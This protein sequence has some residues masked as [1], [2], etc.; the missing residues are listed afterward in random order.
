[1]EFHPSRLP[2]EKI[3]DLRDEKDAS[4]AAEEIVRLGFEN[5]KNG[6]RMLMPKDSTVAKRIGHIVTTGV[7]YGLRQKNKE[8]DIMYW[9]YHHDK[10]HY[11]IVFISA[12]VF[13]EL[14]F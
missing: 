2:I 9:T 12:R 1:M 8:R 6:F 13:T 10:D 7:N 14:G 5:R 4:D 11:A 3:F